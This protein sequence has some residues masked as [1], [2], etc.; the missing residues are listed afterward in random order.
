MKFAKALANQL[1]TSTLYVTA[2]PAVFIII[3]RF[4][5]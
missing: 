3:E 4:A 5:S 1:V 2:I